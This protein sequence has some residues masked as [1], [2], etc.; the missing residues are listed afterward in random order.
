MENKPWTVAGYGQRA[1]LQLGRRRAEFVEQAFYL[2]FVGAVP[3]LVESAA[4]L[5]LFVDCDFVDHA[6]HPIIRRRPAKQ[7]SILS[8][9]IAKDPTSRR[10]VVCGPFTGGDHG[11][12]VSLMNF[13]CT[14]FSARGRDRRN[15]TAYARK[16]RVAKKPAGASR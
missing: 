11:T 6:E 9:L 14:A 1:R 16:L 13:H 15:A 4:R 5:S 8:L 3:D 2:R 7:R 12:S 10:Q